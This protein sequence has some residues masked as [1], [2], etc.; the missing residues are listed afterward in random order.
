M[1]V[2]EKIATPSLL[3]EIFSRWF[4]SR[5]WTPRAH[6]L[7]LLSRARDGRSVLLIAP[8]GG[9]KTLAGFL[10]T[11]VEIYERGVKPKRD[12]LDRPRASP[13]RGPAHALHLAAEGAG[14]RH[15]PQPGNAGA[16][17]GSADPHRN[18]HRRYAVLEAPAPAPR[19]AR[20][21]AHDAGAACAAARQRRRALPVRQ[22]ASAW[23]STSCT[24]WS[25]PS[26]ATCCRS[27]SPGCGGWRPISA[28]P[29]FR[30]PSPSPRTCRA[31]WCRNR[32]ANGATPIWSSQMAAPS[33]ASPCC[34]PGEYL[35]WAGHS[36]RHAFPQIYELIKQNKMTLVF[37]NTRSQAEM[38]FHAMWQINDDNLAIALHHG[39]LDVAQ[40]RQGR[41]RH[42]RGQAPRRGLHLVARSRRRLGRHRPRH[43]RR[44]AEGR[45]APACS[46]SAAPTIASMS[47]RAAS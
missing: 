18:A 13:L 8:T 31:S 25:P 32:R 43:Q 47:R 30:R 42:D 9:G 29:G 22:P 5:G 28:S 33:P 15:R 10:P 40:R 38:I 21:P 7:E 45:L 37:V 41:G 17:D 11:L 35:P 27:A 14:G 3:P 19:S 23:C 26:A 6:Q 20:H 2:A 36:A 4:A 24:R 12:G 44:R 34:A 16:R 39:S 46:A 1:S